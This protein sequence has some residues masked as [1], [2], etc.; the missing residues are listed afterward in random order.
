MWYNFD[1]KKFALDMLPPILRKG[2]LSSLIL[3]LL[4]PLV[5]LYARFRLMQQECLEKLSANGQA[6]S[7]EEVLR[8]RFKLRK[9]DI[10]IV[11]AE[12][13]RVVLYY[14]HEGNKTQ[15]LLLERERSKDIY[16]RYMD[17]GRSTPDFYL[18]IPDFL[19]KE[20]AEILRILAQYKPAGRRYKIVY[21]SYE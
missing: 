2:V 13:Q 7:I 3:A 16:I 21:Y 9:G 6:I 5:W 4:V 19:E 8:K 11:D 10:D 20:E 17:E 18:Y 1:V 15:S 14:A 12:E